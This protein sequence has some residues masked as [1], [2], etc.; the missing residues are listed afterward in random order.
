MLICASCQ[1]KCVLIEVS[2]DK[3]DKV[4]SKELASF[5]TEELSEED[6]SI[7]ASCF[8]QTS[9]PTRNTFIM[10]GGENGKTHVW[11]VTVPGGGGGSGSGSGR[12]WGVS[13]VKEF[14]HHKGPIKSIKP[15]PS[16][17]WVRVPC[18]CPVHPICSEIPCPVSTSPHHF[19]QFICSDMHRRRGRRVQN[20]RY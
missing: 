2:L 7:N 11:K 6:M 18:H 4:I 17:P 20:C 8:L 5:G 3:D 9:S 1:E 14:S 19:V 12:E 16:K 13:K 15:H 10:T